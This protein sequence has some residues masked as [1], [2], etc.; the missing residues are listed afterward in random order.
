MFISELILTESEDNED[1]EKKSFLH[2]LTNSPHSYT[3]LGTAVGAGIGLTL[4]GRNRTALFATGLGFLIGLYKDHKYNLSLCD[5]KPDEKSRL[6]CSIRV[7]I[8]LIG[9]LEQKMEKM[10][11]SQNQ[12]ELIGKQIDDRK[13]RVDKL[14]K[15]LAQLD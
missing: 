1:Q 12:A 7:E 11:L 3:K 5:R 4:G 6:E 8:N 14:R 15:R 10:F 2:R 13:K 9:Q